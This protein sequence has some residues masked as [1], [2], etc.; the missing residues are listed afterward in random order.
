MYSWL[1]FLCGRPAIA[2]LLLSTAWAEPLP[3]SRA[4]Q[5]AISHST[6]MGLATADQMKAH[7][8]YL[9]ARNMYLPQLVFGSGL[10]KSFG[11]PL[12]IEGAAPSAFNV[13][14]QS[15]LL[16]PGQRDLIKSADH[17]FTASV[18]NKEEQRKDVTLDAA[19]TYIQL[20]ALSSQLNA[21][22]QQNTNAQRL[23]E[24]TEQRVQQGV[25][26]RIN[27]TR[28]Q[29]V[30]AQLRMRALQ[31]RGSSDELREHLAQLTG[32]PADSIE[33]V[34]ESIPKLPEVDQ[35]DP[36]AKSLTNNGVVKSAEERAIA[37]EFR[38]RGEHKQL[39]PS[40]DI[41]GQYA[42]LTKYNNYDKFFASFQRN[43]ATLG[44][45]IRV[46]FLNFAQRSHAQQADAD[47]LRAKNEARAVK[48]QVSTQT[49]KLQRTVEQLAAAQEV[50][51]LQYELAQAQAE[52]QQV[53]AQSGG[54][55]PQAGGDQV[56]EIAAPQG[57]LSPRDVINARIQ[58]GDRYLDYLDSTFQ[59]DKARLQLLRQ[60][61][62]LDKWASGQTLT[63]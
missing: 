25:E 22:Q 3:F 4:L 31:L 44:V 33:T 15:F 16:N 18:V 14:Y 55:A 38:A 2:L 53:Q 54:A 62:E 37:M 23:V 49:L 40:I 46:P 1:R 56:Q 20:D 60:T 45:A 19:V 26:S 21:L 58:A 9:E 39:Y 8:A 17:Q 43:N 35:Q 63:P 36:V 48:D 59:L 57:A 12:S 52:A 47:A 30:A 29:L 32:L 34:P 13:N 50:A 41:V 27:G 5:L 24:I 61:G 7:Q 10:A 51:K 6:A 11:F 28:S 42:L